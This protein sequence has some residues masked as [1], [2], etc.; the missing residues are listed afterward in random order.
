MTPETVESFRRLLIAR[1]DDI[2]ALEKANDEDRATV[3]LDQQSVGRLSRMDAIQRQAMAQETRRRRTLELQRIANAL[4][5]IDEGEYGYCAKC[6]EEV[7]EGRL[8]VDPTA[9]LC[10]D[11]A[12]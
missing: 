3:A 11:C 5:L 10:I 12:R 6:G 8:R 1:R 2:A 4:R 7:G 9:T